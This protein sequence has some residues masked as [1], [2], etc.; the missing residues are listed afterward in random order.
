M[1]KTAELKRIDLGS[2][3]KVAF[4]L[5]AALGLFAGLFYGLI[6]MLIGQFGGLLGEDQIPGLR[7]LT[8]FVG[9]LAVPVIATLY[10]ILGSVVVVA[11]G[12]LYNLATRWAGGVKLELD[13]EGSAPG[14]PAVPSQPPMQ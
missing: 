8:G 2:L 14:A 3:F 13:V 1:R 10:G 6:F 11:G 5:Y 4:V 12:A 9:V 7:Y